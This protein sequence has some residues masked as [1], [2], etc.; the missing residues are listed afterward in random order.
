MWIFS[1]FTIIS[2][3]ILNYTKGFTATEIMERRLDG[4]QTTLFTI[5]IITGFKPIFKLIK[6]LI[7]FIKNMFP[8]LFFPKRK[9]RNLENKSTKQEQQE[10]LL[11]QKLEQIKTSQEEILSQIEKQ[12]H[13][14]A[15]WQSKKERKRLLKSQKKH[16]PIG[17]ENQND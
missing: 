8:G 2:N 5:L 12:K 4:I 15:I 17:K 11:L 9:L 10:Q 13:K 16:T 1:I 3:F 6:K 14:V 7:V